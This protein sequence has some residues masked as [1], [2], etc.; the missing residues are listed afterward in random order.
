M[1]AELLPRL[2]PPVPGSYNVTPNSRSWTKCAP[3][4]SSSQRDA[5][6][7]GRSGLVHWY[8]NLYLKY[9]ILNKTNIN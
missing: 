9:K 2:G 5:T 3:P 6:E 8:K 1:E 4:H 7:K